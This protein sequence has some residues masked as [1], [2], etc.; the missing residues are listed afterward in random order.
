MTPLCKG[1][2]IIM[3]G[4]C[5]SGPHVRTFDNGKV[6]TVFSLRYNQTKNDAGEKISDYI[7]IESWGN[8]ARYAACVEKGDDIFVA[9]E[10]AK[11]NYRSEKKGEDIYVVK[12]SIILA[13][14]VADEMPETE[15]D[16]LPADDLPE[17]WTKPKG[18]VDISYEEQIE[19]AQGELPY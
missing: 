18:G 1:K 11:D 4:T 2:S 19:A 12:A 7:D 14:P 16:E 17:E 6:K 3:W 15:E 10:Y 8:L 13:Q 9:G 5:T